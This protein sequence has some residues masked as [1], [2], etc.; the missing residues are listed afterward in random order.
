[1][2]GDT[3][4]A[5]NFGVYDGVIVRSPWKRSGVDPAT[6]GPNPAPGAFLSGVPDPTR[7]GSD[8]RRYIQHHDDR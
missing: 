6:C 2:D 7:V 4:G 1:M 8:Y 3:P 5:K